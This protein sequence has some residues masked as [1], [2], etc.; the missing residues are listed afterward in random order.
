[1]F[2]NIDYRIWSNKKI[3]IML[4]AGSLIISIA[5]RLLGIETK[6]AIRWIQIGKISIQPSEFVKVAMIVVTAGYLSWLE[7]KGRM[8]HWLYSVIIPLL[9]V[10]M[11]SGL[12]FKLQN[13]LSAA[14][15]ITATA[16][17]QMVIAGVNFRTL[18]L[19]IGSGGVLGYIFIAS[20][21]AALEGGF[22]QTRIMVW[23]DPFKYIKTSGWQT[24]QGLLALGSGGLLGAGIG[25]SRQKQN[26]IPEPQNDFIFAIYAEEMGYI[27][28]VITI[29]IFMLLVARGMQIA[30]KAPDLFGKLLAFGV[31]TLLGL[32]IALNLAVVS[33]TIP[34]TGISLPLFSY[35][36]S[37]IITTFIALGLL[38]SVSKVTDEEKKQSKRQ[39]QKLIK[40]IY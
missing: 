3:L 14:I 4:F 34:V 12:I 22:R 9:G 25:N 11:I 20:K 18:L 13:H 33:N 35:G 28:V 24:A 8:K 39:A 1:M 32:Q 40:E 23:Q 29:I 5:V 17:L 26:Y 31:T 38:A 19:T 7:E 27:L 10:F 6:G 21:F 2:L 15:L 37:A 30:T 16:F 36:G